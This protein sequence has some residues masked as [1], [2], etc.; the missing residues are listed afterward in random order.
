[1]IS[2]FEGLPD[3]GGHGTS[4]TSP[5]LS[6]GELRLDDRLDPLVNRRLQRP[7][8]SETVE[9]P[10]HPDRGSLPVDR[11]G[12]VLGDPG[13]VDPSVVPVRLDLSASGLG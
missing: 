4:P 6:P 9:V 1:M 3:P 11:S 12:Q 2:S 10:G 7:E 5:C 13:P 8:V